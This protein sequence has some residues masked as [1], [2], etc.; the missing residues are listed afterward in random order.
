MT[1]NLQARDGGDDTSSVRAI[2]DRLDGLSDDDQVSLGAIIQAFGQASFLPVMLIPALLVVSPLS[3]IPFFSSV[4]GLSIALIAAQLTFGRDHLWLP[5]VLM[6]RR[7]PGER[8]HSAMGRMRRFAD[9]LDRHARDRLR[10]LVVPPVVVLSRVICIL[11]GLAM[12]FLELVPFSSSILGAAVTLITV[13][14]LA[15][16]GLYVLGGFVFV[17]IASLVPIFVAGH[18][19]G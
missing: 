8:L 3:G 19:A 15:R 2:V 5:G 1:D 12:P 13:G 4:C 10:V 11:A 9:W 7:I 14:F 6:R 18:I 16:D 17:G